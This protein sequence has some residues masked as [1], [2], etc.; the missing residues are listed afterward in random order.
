MINL[1]ILFTAAFAYAYQCDTGGI[2]QISLNTFGKTKE[3]LKSLAYAP[4]NPGFSKYYFQKFGGKEDFVFFCHTGDKAHSRILFLEETGI[5]SLKLPIYYYMSGI[6]HTDL[7][8]NIL[9][10]KGQNKDFYVQ[11]EYSDVA[12]VVTA[13]K[14]PAI[15]K[16]MMISMT[17]IQ[18]EYI[19]KYET[20]LKSENKESAITLG[21][22]DE[23]EMKILMSCLE[24]KQQDVV[25]LYL[26]TKF[27]SKFP[28]YGTMVDDSRNRDT[29]SAE[30]KSKYQRPWAD[31][32]AEFIADI[33]QSHPSCEGIVSAESKLKAFE[34]SFAKNKQVY[35]N[36]RRVFFP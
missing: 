21:V 17:R 33:S 12:T 22:P 16:D 13:D 26:Q 7:P 4:S 18:N 15:S 28:A 11:Y 25:D 2:D 30:K 27:T 36:L 1:L 20:W 14:L 23:S 3:C 5:Q 6:D 34:H 35:E 19:K 8:R 31:L 9:H 32:E 10:F 24:E 29:I